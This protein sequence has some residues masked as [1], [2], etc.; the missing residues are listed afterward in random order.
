MVRRPPRHKLTDTIF[1]YTTLFRSYG[2]ELYDVYTDYY[3]ELGIPTH[4]ELEPVAGGAERYNLTDYH[5]SPMAP[6]SEAGYGT[7]YHFP[8]RGWVR[9]PS[10]NGFADTPWS[11][12]AQRDMDRSEEHTTELQSL[13]RI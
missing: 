4:A 6:A 1:P 13:M 3:R 8:G 11:P 9:D 7:A 12:A 5:F 10:K 2:G